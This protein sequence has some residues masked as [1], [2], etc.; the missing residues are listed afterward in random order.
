M[1]HPYAM[2]RTILLAVAGAA[3]LSTGV[4]VLR[5]MVHT[6]ASQTAQTQQEQEG[7]L[8]LSHEDPESPE[9]HEAT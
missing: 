5:R 2:R 8:P 6:R 3:L 7:P 4:L 1:P 9:P